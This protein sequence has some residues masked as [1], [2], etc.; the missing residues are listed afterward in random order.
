VPT[1]LT[2]RINPSPVLSSSVA[3]QRVGLD[4]DAS[5]LL[6]WAFIRPRLRSIGLLAFCAALA[7]LAF[8]SFIE[9]PQ[10]RA[11]ALL[12][13]TNEQAVLDRLHGLASESPIGSELFRQEQT[14]AHAQELVSILTS[15]SFTTKLIA[16]Y[17]LAHQLLHENRRQWFFRADHS[18]W[19]LYRAMRERFSSHYDSATG[20][21]VLRFTAGKPDTAR[22]ILHLYIASLRNRLRRSDTN[23]ARVAMS[24]LSR[25]A[26]NESDTIL[27]EHLYSFIAAQ[28][29]RR[30]VALVDADLAFTVIEPPVVPDAPYSPRPLLDSVLAALASTFIYGLAAIAVHSKRVR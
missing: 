30:K 10:Y 22:R 9:E 24:A 14:T 23:D 18:R 12:R 27:R 29:Q 7:T 25:E 4:E 16:T 1:A 13:P 19:G 3:T 17:H 2:H 20:N 5:L 8:T 15:Y 28:S 21:L 6:Y 11:T 26:T